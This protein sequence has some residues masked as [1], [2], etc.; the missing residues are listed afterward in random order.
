[1]A[2]KEYA[3]ASRSDYFANRLRRQ[4]DS[5]ALKDLSRK[6]RPEKRW[7]FMSAPFAD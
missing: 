5:P 1:M 3:R 2:D 6:T 7:L 4:N